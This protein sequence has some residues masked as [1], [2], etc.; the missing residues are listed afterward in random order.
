MMTATE[1][2]QKGELTQ[3]IKALGEEL[4]GNPL[5]AKRRTFL[6]ELL[7]FAG[8]YDRAEKQ[9]DVLAH[10]DSKAAPAVLL[11]RS[12]L[13]AERTRQEMFLSGSFPPAPAEPEPDRAGTWN[14]EPFSYLGDADDVIGDHLECFI[15]GAYTWLPTKY[16][17]RLEI[18]P[19]KDLRDL[20][21]ARAR[22]DASPAFRLQELGEVLLPVLSPLSYR[23]ADD[24][25]KLGRAS[26]WETAADGTKRPMGQKMLLVDGKEIPLLE[27]RTI[28][29]RSSEAGVEESV[30][31]A[32]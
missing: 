17:D 1:L 9:L 3:A 27:F 26:T 18:E 22:L 11:Y 6:F 15:A 13:H 8:E 5:D 10:Q 29:F 32:P 7:C 14:G 20:F 23:A 16:I 30:D 25:V 28:V 31:A 4:R 21:W 12:A 24:A 19:P 2:Y